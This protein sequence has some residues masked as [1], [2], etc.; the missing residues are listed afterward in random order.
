M[1]NESSLGFDT[2]MNQYTIDDLLGLLDLGSNPS[3][4]EIVNK[5]TVNN[6]NDLLNSKFK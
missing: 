6:L 1:V 5:I 2:S 4:S 3:Q